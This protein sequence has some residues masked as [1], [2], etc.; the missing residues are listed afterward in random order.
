MIMS[1]FVTLF[2]AVG[3]MIFQQVF[4]TNAPRHQVGTKPLA[5]VWWTLV[6]FVSWWQN[7][8]LNFLKSIRMTLFLLCFATC[9][10]GQSN[11]LQEL[12]EKNKAD[13]GVW[14][15]DP[16]QYEVQV[17]YTQIDRDKNN[18]PS[19]KSH[20]LGVDPK[21]YFYPASTIKMPA[22]FAALEKLNR[23]NIRGL[24][25][26]TPMK[27]GA[28]TPPQTPV[29]VD[30]SAANFLP[31]IAHYIRKIFLVSDNDAY[32]R[33]YEFLGQEYFNRVLWKK[34]YQDLRMITRLSAPGFNP[35]NNRYTNPVSF[36]NYDTLLYYQGEVFSEFQAD[37]GLEQE[38]RGVAYM[39]GNSDIIDEPFDFTTKN[40][41]SLQNL[42]DILK[43]VI[44]PE[45]VP[46]SARFDLTEADYDLIYRAMYEY[47]RE[48]K[49][50]KYDEPDNYVKF[51]LFG[52]STENIPQHIR[53]FNKV[54]WAYG[55][56]TDVAYIVDFVNNV[57]FMVAGV[58][59]VNANQTYNDG[60]YE[61]EE[62]G[63]PFFAEL[64]ELLYEYELN[65]DREVVPDLGRF[66][67]E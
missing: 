39:D 63:L 45:A 42:H 55:F 18:H 47:P 53:I 24:D 59:H 66:R 58:I 5:N 64:G 20:T 19:F 50:P 35:D 60:V 28:V 15:Q 29:V 41:I 37:L 67:V 25:A 2:H 61:Y 57:E 62:I 7:T 38:I 17:I 3:S 46:A 31:S 30:T 16:D 54:G 48:S 12:I 1:Y 11:I 34:G 27:T 9:L 10:W 51:W 32:N 52:D 43:S 22:A 14:A 65:R 4:A 33:L 44:F 36:Y 21:R 23:L 8:L 26:N 40:F 56:L 13:L 6:N 49:Y